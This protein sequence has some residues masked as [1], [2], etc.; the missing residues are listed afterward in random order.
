MRQRWAGDWGVAPHGK[1]PVARRCRPSMFDGG[2]MHCTSPVSFAAAPATA[3]TRASKT[4]A[5]AWPMAMKV[6]GSQWPVVP[7]VGLGKAALGSLRRRRALPPRLRWRRPA[8]MAAASARAEP[9]SPRL[10]SKW[11]TSS[12]YTSGGLFCGE[13]ASVCCPLVCDLP[14]ALWIF[15]WSCQGCRAILL[16]GV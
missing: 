12:F 9:S 1:G 14:G 13:L 15:W 5:A 10:S 16:I 6:G 8:T 7:V 3:V 2:A 4:A 11:R